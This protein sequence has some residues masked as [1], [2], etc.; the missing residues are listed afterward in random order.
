MKKY[1]FFITIVGILT[2]CTEVSTNSG[3]D[4]HEQVSDNTENEHNEDIEANSESESIDLDKVYPFMELKELYQSNWK[5]EERGN[6]VWDGKTVTITG[7]VFSSGRMSKLVD[8]EVQLVGA[9]LE[10]R[11]SDFKDPNFGHDFECLFP[12]DQALKIADIA[13]GTKVTVKGI[14]DKQEGYIEPGLTYNVLTLKD[15]KLVD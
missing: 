11:G 4:S 13:T 15:C 12:K 6:S 9:K 2:A 14:V 7:E 5:G 3:N 1:L 8:G 10:F